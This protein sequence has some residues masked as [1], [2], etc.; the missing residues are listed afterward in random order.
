MKLTTTFKRLRSCNACKPRY[1]LLR[2]ALPAEEYR[3]DTPINLLTILETNGLDDALWALRAT[4]QNCDKIARLMAADFAEMVLPI[5]EA[6]Y[7]E[8]KRPALAIETARDYANGL[9]SAGQM[10][11]I[12]SDAWN[13][14]WDN[15][16]FG[17]LA[18]TEAARSALAASTARS[19]R[20]VKQREIFVRYLQE[21]QTNEAE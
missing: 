9:I 15:V 2:T 12:A 11:T 5:W 14:T 16:Q 3:D 21:E 17:H 18:E 8:D 20:L 19:D 13:A 1:T 7:P 10:G 6:K 4:D